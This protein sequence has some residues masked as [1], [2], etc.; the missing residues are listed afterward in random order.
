MLREN[1]KQPVFVKKEESQKKQRTVQE[2]RDQLMPEYKY[3]VKELERL[4]ESTKNKQSQKEQKEK[5]WTEIIELGKKLRQK[6]D[7][8]KETIKGMEE[9]LDGLEIK[10]RS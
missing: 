6:L 7:E 10:M 4:F 5:I 3:S 8:S 9:E 2:K 1:I